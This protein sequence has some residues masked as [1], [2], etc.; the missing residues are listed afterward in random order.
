MDDHGPGQCHPLALAE[1]HLGRE[2]VAEAGQPQALQQLRRFGPAAVQPA[3]QPQ[4]QLDVLG[5]A[6]LVDQAEVLGHHR[7][8][9][10]RRH[11]GWP[12]PEH[13][14]RQD[15]HT[16]HA[17]ELL[18]DGGVAGG[19]EQP[20]RGG[21]ERQD[22]RRGDHGDRD[23]GEMDQ[24]D[25]RLGRFTGWPIV[26]GQTWRSRTWSA[27]AER[28]ARTGPAGT[29]ARAARAAS[30]SAW[31]VRRASVRAGERRSRSRATPTAP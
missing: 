16:A 17:V 24:P 15:R 26:P 13:D 23:A 4:R 6:E 21:R 29:P 27:T 2:A 9:L 12:V 28:A 14:H 30:T 10:H 20:A 25:R 3:G 22:Q 31:A 5:H 18:G 19:Q 1:R 8:L 11:I 7:R